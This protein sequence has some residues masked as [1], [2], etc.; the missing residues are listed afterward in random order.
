MSY[1]PIELLVARFPGNEFTG[2]LGSAFE[3]LVG[4][5]TVRI[6]DF[7]LVSKDA[8]GTVEIAEID[9]LSEAAFAQLDP[10]V[11]EVSG[12]ISEDDAHYFG[13]LLEPNSS[14]A[15]LL[16]ENA[17]V[18]QFAELF[19]QARGEIILNERVPHAVIEEILAKAE[20][21]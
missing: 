3:V 14:E 18:V 15:L 9:A 21:R 10:I 11:A 6:I 5:G 1:G 2:E 20:A 8:Q 12:L 4:T 16:F 13:N 7:L 17:W 19:R